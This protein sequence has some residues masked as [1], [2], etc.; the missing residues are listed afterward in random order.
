M[1]EDAIEEERVVDEDG[2]AGARCGASC[3]SDAAPC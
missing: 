1:R 3:R 2:N